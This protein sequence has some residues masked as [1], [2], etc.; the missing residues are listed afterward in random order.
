MLRILKRFRRYLNKTLESD[1]LFS[2]KFNF[3][4]FPSVKVNLFIRLFIMLWHALQTFR[5]FLWRTEIILIFT[6]N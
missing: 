3:S 1:N 2:V 6:I 5:R 4:S